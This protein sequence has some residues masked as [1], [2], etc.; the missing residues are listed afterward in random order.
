MSFQALCDYIAIAVCNIY[1][2]LQLI[3]WLKLVSFIPFYNKIKRNG[4]TG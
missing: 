2:Q 1:K 4:K 3:A